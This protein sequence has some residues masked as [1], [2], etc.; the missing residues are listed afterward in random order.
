VP[1]A[2]SG[3]V[4]SATISA[5]GTVPSVWGLNGL[6]LQVSV[7]TP[8]L[9]DLS[10]LAGRPLPDIRDVVFESHLGDAGFRLHGVDARELNFTSSL[11]ELAG[12]VTFAWSPVPTLNGTLTSKHFD[13]DAA[14]A[15]W[16]AFT[17]AAPGAPALQPNAP[18][19]PGAAPGP[20]T[21]AATPDATANR[22]FSDTPLPFGALHGADADLTLVAGSLTIGH[23]TYRDLNVKLLAND[24]K[25]ILNPLRVTAPQGLLTGALSLDASIDPPPVAMTL[26]SPSMSAGGLAA[27][28]GYPGA[29]SGAVQLDAQLSGVGTTPHALAAS[30]TGHFGM[31]MVNG[32]VTDAVLEGALGAALDAAGVPPIGGSTD[33]RCFALR[34]DF[35]HGQGE[36]QALSLDTSRLSLD[37]D[38]TVDLGDETL[39]LHLRPVVRVGGSGVAAPVL[40]H[41][42]FHSL[43]ASLEPAMDGG[44][45]GLTIG[46]PAP[47]DNACVGKLAD[48]R[49][50]LAGPMPAAAPMQAPG[51]GKHKK[52]ADLLRGLFH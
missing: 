9:A 15:A 13:V 11:G 52:P 33:V 49:G 50:G 34:T 45:F 43:K 8:T 38:G 46:G 16:T 3:Q 27:A 24:G 19:A 31:T 6:D 36:V 30:V 47:N 44:R 14:Q 42:G 17:S 40:L 10:P 5:R 35:H 21:P 4:A 39:S 23:E 28:L 29:A 51:N 25:L 37:G 18:G 7:R 2:F 20:D 48:A 41:G 22:V 12:H 32:T 1:L 26:R